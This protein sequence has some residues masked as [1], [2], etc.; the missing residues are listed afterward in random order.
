MCRCMVICLHV[1]MYT[2]HVLVPAVARRGGHISWNWSY[3]WLWA[4]PWVLET[5]TRSSARASGTL[6]HGAISRA[7]A[8]RFYSAILLYTL[9]NSGRIHTARHTELRG[10]AEGWWM[11]WKRKPLLYI[12]FGHVP[13][14]PTQNSELQEVKISVRKMLW[15]WKKKL[16]RILDNENT[17]YA[18]GLVDWLFYIFTMKSNPQIHCDPHQNSRDILHRTWKKNPDSHGNSKGHG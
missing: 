16:K 11:E 18:P 2:V 9:G 3:K 4:I 5:K 14:L 10:G 8:K 17:P 13:V 7:L 15:H 1:W 12:C 6:Y